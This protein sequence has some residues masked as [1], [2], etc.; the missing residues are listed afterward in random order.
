M[1]K[2][3]EEMLEDKFED[4]LLSFLNRFQ[5][6]NDCKIKDWSFTHDGDKDYKLRVEVE[7]ECSRLM[8]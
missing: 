6:D 3:I 1:V 2:T 4:E 5:Q 8:S 7:K